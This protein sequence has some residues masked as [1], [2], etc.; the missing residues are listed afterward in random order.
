MPPAFARRERVQDQDSLCGGM[1]PST[2]K[3]AEPLN[4]LKT[5]YAT[6]PPRRYT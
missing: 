1:I 4:V 2:F 5:H 6:L 3:I